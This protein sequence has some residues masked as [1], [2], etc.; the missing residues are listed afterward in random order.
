MTIDVWTDP[1]LTDLVRTDPGLV[2]IADV[3]AQSA[4]R[5]R[6]PRR[7]VAYVVAAATLIAAAVLPAV[8]LSHGLRSLLGITNPPV[9]RNWVQ[10]TLIDPIP[11]SAPA[12]STV[13]V[14]WKLWSYDQHGKVT[15]FG[16]AELF[17][18]IVNPARTRATRAVARCHDGRRALYCHDGRFQARIRVPSGGIGRIQVGIIGYSDGPSGRTSAPGLF[19]ITNYP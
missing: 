1:E 7:R 12:G 19:P 17:A 8:A 16:A 4:I 18:R 14:R 5:K 9:A 11:R 6:S 2:V 3:L 10:A 15:P 13:V